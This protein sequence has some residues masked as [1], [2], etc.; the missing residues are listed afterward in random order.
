VARMERELKQFADATLEEIHERKTLTD[1]HNTQVKMVDA[2]TEALKRSTEDIRHELSGILSEFEEVLPV[3]HSAFMK[4][5]CEKMFAQAED[6]QPGQAP[7]IDDV[8]KP[9]LPAMFSAPSTVQSIRSGI[10]VHNLPLVSVVLCVCFSR[11][12]AERPEPA[13]LH[14]FH[15]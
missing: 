8:S 15:I 12:P 3:V 13:V 2:E 4:I 9:Q 7:D 5:G 1:K 14:I 10:S 6:A 11:Q